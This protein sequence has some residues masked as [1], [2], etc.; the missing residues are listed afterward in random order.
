MRLRFIKPLHKDRM[1]LRGPFTEDMLR[2]ASLI[3]DLGYN[4]ATLIQ[5]WAHALLWKLR[6]RKAEKA[7]AP[8][9]KK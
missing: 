8:P 1:L 5:F 3:I 2:V 7:Q 6:K 9:K 4:P